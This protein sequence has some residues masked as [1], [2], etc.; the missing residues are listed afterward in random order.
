MY[1]IGYRICDYIVV[2]VNEISILV[3]DF[4]S[5]YHSVA[6]VELQRLT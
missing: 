2:L 4:S 5:K 3:G 6:C 1:R